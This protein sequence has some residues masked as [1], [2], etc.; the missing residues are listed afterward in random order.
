MKL[1]LL[2]C[3]GGAV[4]AGLRHVANVMAVRSLG[5]EVAWATLTVNVIGSFLMGG[6]FALLYFKW[7]DAMAIRIFFAT[8]VLGGFTTFSAFSLDAL[9]F[10]ERG[11]IGLALG[12]ILG[13]VI[14]SVGACLIGYLCL[15]T[16]VS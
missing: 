11:A 4:G 8:G 13:S 1:I 12:Y 3:A 15:R 10:L 16:L 2:A 7:P 5:L 9:I 14:L 6:L